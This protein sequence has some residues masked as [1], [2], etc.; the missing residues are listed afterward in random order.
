M[1]VEVLFSNSGDSAVDYPDTVPTQSSARYEFAICR[2]PDSVPDPSS[3]LPT[4]RCRVDVTIRLFAAARAAAGTDSTTARPGSL[5]EILEDLATRYPGLGEVLP[6]CSYLVD[7]IATH[8]LLEE[9]VVEPGSQVD[10]LPPFAG[11]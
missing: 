5:A 9:I 6:R 1:V 7:A 11:G 3:P 2:P 10:V 4:Y 8:G